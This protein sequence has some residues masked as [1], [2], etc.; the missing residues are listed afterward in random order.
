MKYLPLNITT[1]YSLL[2]S[3]IK[4]EDLIKFAKENN[5]K[6]LTITDDNLYGVM[7]FYKLC[8]L[9]KI[10]PIVGLRIKVDGLKIILYC[11]NYEG[12]K[13]LIKINTLN[14]EERLTLNDLNV[15]R[16]DLI[17][18][19]PFSSLG[20]YNDLEKIFPYL[21]KS[22]QN[23]E[24][25]LKLNGSNLVYMDEI[26]Y[27]TKK[28]EQ[29]FNYLLAIRDGVFESESHFNFK[30]KYLKLNDEILMDDLQ[31]NEMIND[32]CHLEL[33]FNYSLIPKFENPQGE[34]SFIYLKRLCLNSL[35]NM[36]PPLEQENYHKRLNQEL[37]I[38]NKMGF[39]DYFLIVWDYVKYA[40]EQGILVGP[41]RGSAA[42][43]LVS[44]L[45]NITMV[46]PLK[47][48][49]LFERFLNPERITMPDIDI[50]FEDGRR[51]EVIHYC[52]TK[53]GPKRVAPIITFGTLGSKQVIRDVARTM[54]IDLKVVDYLSKKIQSHLSLKENYNQN[55]QLRIYLKNKP[56]LIKMYK[57]ASKLE[58]LKRHTS[59]HAAGIVMSQVDLDEIIPI[60]KKDDNGYLTGYDMEYLETIGLLKM[61]FLGLRNLTL[62]SD[63]LKDLKEV[64]GV[65][66]SFL[67]I[68]L[69]DR[70]ALDLFKEGK[71][72]GL[73]QF[74][75]E[76]MKNFLRKLRPSCFEDICAANALFRPGPMQNIDTYIKRKQGQVKTEIIHPHLDKILKPTY[77]IIVYQ[78]QIMQIVRVLANYSFAKADLLRRAMSKKQ[79]LVIEQEKSDFIKGC[80][81]NGYSETLANQVYA[82]ILKFASYGFNRSHAVAYSMIASKMAYLKVHYPFFFMKSLLSMVVGSEIKTKEYIYECKNNNIRIISPDIN[83]SSGEY[84]VTKKGIVYPLSIIKQVGAA[85][86]KTIIEERKKGSYKDIFDFIKRVYGKSVNKKTIISL[87][88]AGCF[89]SIG[90]NKRTITENLDI[91]INYGELIKD[92]GEEFVLEPEINYLSEYS[93]KEL[94]QLEL[95]TF[96]FYLSDHPV[97]EYRIRNPHAI[98]L[99]NLESYFD[100]IVETI[101]YV[102]RLK[103][104]K[105]KHGDEMCFITGSDEL[106]VIDIVLFPKVFSRY[107]NIK[108]GEIIKVVGKVEKRFDKLQIIANLLEVLEEE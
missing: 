83:L 87:V 108:T 5:L 35:N 59:V 43:S 104:I 1:H 49:L 107:S 56:T 92:I 61:D 13:N 70:Q 22:Y 40:K 91:I 55:K 99:N 78:E 11:C 103:K 72:I 71:T 3:M 2:S 75:S 62:I 81:N 7:E 93:K 41:G 57:I 66:V 21:F 6:Q 95:E 52:L 28:D 31:N 77:G 19:V 42:G 80:L 16:E 63:I 84:L 86:T 94:M 25:K 88:N 32:L 50:D 27:L 9:N 45:L 47:Y 33:K 53:Y 8:T 12:Y 14:F 18:L 64:L 74:E 39:C 102:D 37:E 44:Y 106:K 29:Y 82:L 54:S 30:N 46:D 60:V 20:L 76:G 17:C 79:V 51:E 101:V 4:I 68:P 38:I 100:K 10:K 69:D 105:T 24:E 65:E 96:G 67:D 48:G 23:K 15:Y 58:G 97:T 90:L 36:I 73:F 34:D 85:A 26:L 98:E 89:K